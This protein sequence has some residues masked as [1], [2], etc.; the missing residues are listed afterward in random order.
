MI[1]NFFPET[2]DMM[3]PITPL[4]LAN[5]EAENCLFFYF[6]LPR[7]RGIGSFRQCPATRSRVM[8]HCA[9]PSAF[10]GACVDEAASAADAG[11]A[12]ALGRIVEFVFPGTRQRRIA[13]QVGV[14]V[15]G[16]YQAGLVA[17][18]VGVR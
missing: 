3:L 5:A 16:H 8:G 7:W 2:D 6:S 1:S 15:L 13:G 17:L 18:P 10:T 4:A 14:P 9:G 12:Q 11:N